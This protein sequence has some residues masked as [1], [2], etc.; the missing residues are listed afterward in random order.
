M[1]NETV[2][3]PSSNNS[4][5]SSGPD[6]RSP[7]RKILDSVDNEPDVEDNESE[8]STNGAESTDNEDEE[9]VDEPSDEED[10]D[11]E[12]DE[13]VEPEEESDDESEDVTNAP[14]LYKALKADGTLKK[15]P[16][17][18]EIIFREQKYAELYP[19]VEDAVGAS[20]RSQ[21]F[22]ALE[23]QVTSGNSE[24]ILSALKPNK[25]QFEDF[26]HNFLPTLNKVDPQTYNDV[27]AVPFKLALQNIFKGAENR[28]DDQLKWSVIRLHD[29]I[30]GN[31]NISE[32]IPERKPKQNDP[33]VERLKGE[34]NERDTRI[35][36]S[37]LIDTLDIFKKRFNGDVAKS[38]EK[39]DM[40]TYKRNKVNK[41]INDLAIELV[42]KD[43]RHR[44]NMASLWQQAKSAGY[45]TDWKVRIANAFRTRANQYLDE[46]KRQVLAEASGK[47]YS[48]KD[49]AAK[50]N[51]KRPVPSSNASIS[52]GDVSAKELDF[53]KM[54]EKDYLA[55]DVS[56]YVYKKTSKK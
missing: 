39:V 49:I 7:E 15:H 55:G 3:D 56:K 27:M 50:K 9:S 31:K 48:S 8:E 13:E 47:K 19:T 28:G 16:E 52:K 36:N 2:T 14:N 6:Y 11:S 30:W 20:E 4:E 38:T 10:N 1:A 32:Q 22:G 17:L 41:D 45:T 21:V 23:K 29:A 26:V 43:V 54:S 24:G 35:H 44:N 18:R 42:S 12:T 40:D 37:A 5:S 51:I 34:L 46:A 33:E 25:E 53:T